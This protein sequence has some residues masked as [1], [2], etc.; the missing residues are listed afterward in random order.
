MYATELLWDFFKTDPLFCLGNLSFSSIYPLSD[1][2][3]PIYYGKVIDV[4]TEPDGHNKMIKPFVIVGI[5]L[6]AIQIL[7]MM[8]DLSDAK[9][10]PRLRNFI[11]SDMTKKIF[12]T[13]ESNFK[14]VFTGELISQVTK[15]PFHMTTMTDKLKCYII[16]FL[17]TYG[18]TIIYFT[19]LDKIL[20]VGLLIT[21]TAFL[22]ACL[23][24]PYYCKAIA[25]KSADDAND[26]N[27]DID[28][29]L[30]NLISIYSQDQ[31]VNELE[32]LKPQ[33]QTVQASFEKAMNC[34]IKIRLW[35]LPLIIA[36]L[37][38]FLWRC[39]VM[40]EENRMKVSV[41]VSLFIMLL[42]ILGSMVTFSEVCRD[43]IFDFGIISGFDWFFEESKK[44]EVTPERTYTAN[45]PT[46][47]LFLKDVTFAYPGS[48]TPIVEHLDLN[49]KSGEKLGIVGDIGSG[50]STIEKLILKLN[51]P[52]TGEIYFNGK[53]YN[54]ISIKE[55][56]R[57]IG[58]VPQNPILFNRTVLENIRYGNENKVSEEDVIKLLQDLNL[59]QEFDKLEN[60]I[61]TKVGKSGS[62]ISGGQRQA[63][64]LL[65]ILLTNPEVLVLDEPTSS[66]DE[67]TKK[68]MEKLFDNV[69]ENRTVIL[70]THDDYIA[71]Y[72]TR[73]ITLKK[74]KI[75][76]DK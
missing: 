68:T 1:I 44:P 51:L 66:L 72:A 17:I 52:D 38:V 70:V 56:R 11:V 12:D 39:Y 37:W 3:L 14:E 53:S 18:I 65:R 59:I 55:L 71:K 9:F 33:E 13:Y 2:V 24:S 6:V 28:D 7:H 35:V 36:F 21:I 10:T 63:V 45:V 54:D 34:S 4:V 76:E 31:K 5:L 62:K 15:I 74:G 41:F 27:E 69:M 22:C 75:V 20:G 64:T 58:Y 61:H 57:R 32:R 25:L 8:S 42:Y 26:L 47:G 60:G 29:D 67:K 43:L 16:P 49:I 23:T 30:R 50:K 40:I 19:N 48:S 46:E 73:T